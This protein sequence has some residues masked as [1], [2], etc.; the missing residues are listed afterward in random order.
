MEGIPLV[1]LLKCF[2]GAA[3]LH[4]SG[5]STKS[6]MCWAS[7]RPLHSKERTL[8]GAHILTIGTEVYRMNAWS[9][10]AGYF[11]ILRDSLNG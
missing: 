8:G 9:S 3:V 1:L 10:V 5:P 6:R 2:V 7:F 11:C 4:K